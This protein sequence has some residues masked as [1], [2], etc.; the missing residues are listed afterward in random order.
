[1]LLRNVAV[2]WNIAC[3][4]CHPDGSHV[5]GKR[6]GGAGEKAILKEGSN[7]KGMSGA[8]QV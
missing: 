3:Y 1:M 6:R 8:S 4:S 7:G 2:G 5:E